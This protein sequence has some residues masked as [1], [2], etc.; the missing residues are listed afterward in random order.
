[1][2]KVCGF[3]LA[4]AFFASAAPA[5]AQCTGNG[6]C[7]PV[8]LEW[9]VPQGFAGADFRPSC[10]AHDRCYSTPGVSR[11]SC[12]RQFHRG[13]VASCDNSRHPILCRLTA[14]SMFGMTRLF[15]GPAFRASQRGWYTD[16]GFGFR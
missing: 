1:M 15:G 9:A 8:G 3:V 16:R 11:A 13:L 10:A 12:D 6:P 2:A 4:A 5:L 7:G 14:H